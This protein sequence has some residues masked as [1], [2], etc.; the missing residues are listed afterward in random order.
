M[1]RL[2]VQGIWRSFSWGVLGQLMWAY[3]Q[4]DIEGEKDSPLFLQGFALGISLWG[5]STNETLE[6][7]FDQ[8][9]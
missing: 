2:S 7:A 4:G 3:L 8:V 1:G 5:S 9:E 6:R